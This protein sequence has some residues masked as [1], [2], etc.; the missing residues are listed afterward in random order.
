MII[1][2]HN[3]ADVLYDLAH[4]DLSLQQI[5]GRLEYIWNIRTNILV[6]LFS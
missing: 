5:R 3:L 4:N 2:A 6:I 1:M